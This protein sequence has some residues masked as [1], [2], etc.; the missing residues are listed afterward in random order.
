MIHA[1]KENN[2]GAVREMLESQ[3]VVIEHR[4]EV[5]AS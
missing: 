4:D 1:V 2:I 5:F 3:E